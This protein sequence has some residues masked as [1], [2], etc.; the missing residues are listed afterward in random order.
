MSVA[1]GPRFA[2]APAARP[3]V[4]VRIGQNNAVDATYRDKDKL[5]LFTG[6]LGKI[7]TALDEGRV[8]LVGDPAWSNFKRFFYDQ[9]ANKTEFKDDIK[10]FLDAFRRLFG[11]YEPDADLRPGV[12]WSSFKELYS[13]ILGPEPGGNEGQKNSIREKAFNQAVSRVPRWDAPLS[14]ANDSAAGDVRPPAAQQQQRGQALVAVAQQ[15]STVEAY[16]KILISQDSIVVPK[17][18]PSDYMNI[19]QWIRTLADKQNLPEDKFQQLIDSY[20]R[21]VITKSQL[22]G[23][24]GAFITWELFYQKAQELSTEYAARRIHPQ[25][26][27]F[28]NE[29]FRRC[30]NPTPPGQGASPEIETRRRTANRIGPQHSALLNVLTD[31]APAAPC[32]QVPPPA[33]SHSSRRPQR[34]GRTKRLRRLYR[35]KNLSRSSPPN[36]HT[37]WI[38][39]R[40]CKR[41]WRLRSKRI[42]VFATKPVPQ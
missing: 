23:G 31:P 36:L 29:T 4:G 20:H 28:V 19:L 41:S 26:I 24:S 5:E 25:D 38:S 33:N 17:Q 42:I 22:P 14:T 18:Q 40:Q 11:D 15:K 30:I 8:T 2:A 1:F 35:S 10:P 7:V 27:D 21:V 9:Y 34:A 6:K 3:R 13:S 39:F 12:S 37:P 32:A 16:S